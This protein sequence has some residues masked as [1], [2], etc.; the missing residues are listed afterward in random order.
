MIL[1]YMSAALES[2]HYEL[3]EDEEP[4]YGSVPGLEG[5]WASGKSLEECR[6]NLSSALEDWI[7]FSV[8]M[9]VALPPVRGVALV[10]PDK[11]A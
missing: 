1:D 8:R 6:R 10:V 7:L 11:V 9:G 4:F 2:A 5:V 3:I